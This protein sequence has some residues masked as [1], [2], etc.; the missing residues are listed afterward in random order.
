MF[1]VTL[2]PIYIRNRGGG[3]P[4]ESETISLSYYY[5]PPPH[6]IL[7][8]FLVLFLKCAILS[9]VKKT[10]VFEMNV[11]VTI[12]NH[13]IQ[14]TLDESRDLYNQLNELFG[15]VLP[16]FPVTWYDESLNEVMYNYE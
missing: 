5:L 10:G 15:P 2:L 12:R 4:L 16:T 3:T 8:T 7:P 1:I 6:K 11:V 14:L 9:K 13:E